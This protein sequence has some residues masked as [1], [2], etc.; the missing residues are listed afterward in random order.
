[1]PWR[2]GSQHIQEA[3][4]VPDVQPDGSRAVLVVMRDVTRERRAEEIH[5]AAQKLEALQRFSQGVAHDVGNL[6]TAVENYARFGVRNL[7]ALQQLAKMASSENFLEDA[8]ALSSFQQTLSRLHYA[9][10]RESPSPEISASHRVTLMALQASEVLA[11]MTKTQTTVVQQS[12]R[13][14]A[15]V[16]DLRQLGE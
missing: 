4:V 7:T 11:R 9:L 3:R 16:S 1:V 6:L 2:D 8:A 12:E 10:H 13:I 5:A 14:K 15:L